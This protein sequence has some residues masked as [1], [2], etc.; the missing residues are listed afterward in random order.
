[1]FTPNL[2]GTTYFCYFYFCRKDGLTVNVQMLTTDLITQ[3]SL[4]ISRVLKK[5]LFT[6]FI[7]YIFILSTT[8][9][10]YKHI[11]ATKSHLSQT[12]FNNNKAVMWFFMAKYK[13]TSSL[14]IYL[15]YTKPQTWQLQV[16][17]Q[18]P[19]NSKLH[20]WQMHHLMKLKNIWFWWTVLFSDIFLL[21]SN[22]LEQRI[23]IS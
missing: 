19:E 15:V 9:I 20:G 12:N 8:F 10:I 5:I 14:C 22:Y 7:F 6:G 11:L 1:M 23:Q 21:L 13:F 4:R 3:I 2:S 16:L 18:Y 17:I